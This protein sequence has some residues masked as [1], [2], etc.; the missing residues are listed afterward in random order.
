MLPLTRIGFLL[1]VFTM[2]LTAIPSAFSSGV[3]IN[4]TRVIINQGQHAVPVTLRNNTKDTAYLVQSY[5][6][7][8]GT[9]QA[10]MLPI[11]VLPPL[12]HLAPNSQHDI[13]IVEKD[14]LTVLLPM[15]RESVFYFHARAI[16]NNHHKSI[17]AEDK[18]QGVIKIALEN[19]IKVFY[20]P[21]NLSSS[22]VQAQAGLVFKK[23]PKGLQVENPSPYYVTLAGLTLGKY[24]VSLSQ[25]NL[26]LSPFSEVT[27]PTSS[28]EKGTNVSWTTIN[29]LGGYNTHE[30][31]F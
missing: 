15:D 31:K 16:P 25:Q 27:Y 30:T 5:I 9:K 28:S 19:V 18:N 17:A 4:A 11:E 20:R 24:P 14:N 12:F 23:I 1:V 7:D 3:G 29:D 2:I 10:E 26:M 21:K 13:R 8:K 6:S 22:S